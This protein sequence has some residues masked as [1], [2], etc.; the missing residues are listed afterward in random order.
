MRITRQGATAII[1]VC[2]I[3]L[4][5][6]FFVIPDVPGMDAWFD[7]V[8]PWA[9]IIIG[10]LAVVNTYL[11]KLDRYLLVAMAILVTERVTL[12]AILTITGERPFGWYT[13]FVWIVVYLAPLFAS[14]L[15]KGRDVV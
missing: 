13:A 3:I 1:G 7:N 11:T 8:R 15:P 10:L 14:A 4:G 5:I 6:G 12:F 2:W 9:W